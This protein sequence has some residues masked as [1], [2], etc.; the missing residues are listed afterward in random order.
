MKIP[1]PRRIVRRNPMAAEMTRNP[2]YRT[3][4][5]ASADEIAQKN[6]AWD[7]NAK[8]KGVPETDD[9]DGDESC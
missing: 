2:L 3:R 5:M 9:D 7:R 4:V 1:K 6:N 8:H